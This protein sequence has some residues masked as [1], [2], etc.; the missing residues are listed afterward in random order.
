MIGEKIFEDLKNAIVE[1]DDDKAVKGAEDS[2]AQGIDPLESIDK[3]LSPGID[4]VYWDEFK[5]STES[6]SST[7]GGKSSRS[8]LNGRQETHTIR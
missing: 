1:L 7:R 5:F 3:G 2:I 6:R 4:R 8:L